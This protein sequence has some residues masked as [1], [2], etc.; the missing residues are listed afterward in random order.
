MADDSFVDF[1]F[2]IISSKLLQNILNLL[3]EFA[4]VVKMTIQMEIELCFKQLRKI[5]KVLAAYYIHRTATVGT[6]LETIN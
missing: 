3:T 6:D 2:I 5:N 1:M 4:S